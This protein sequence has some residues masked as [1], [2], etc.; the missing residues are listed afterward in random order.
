MKTAAVN[1]ILFF[2]KVR[3]I[4]EPLVTVHRQVSETD[5]SGNTHDHTWLYRI[6][7]AE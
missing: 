4:A 6:C 3:Q 7:W 1:P 5:E 2:R